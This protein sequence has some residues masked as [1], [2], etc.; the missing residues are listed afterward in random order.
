MGIRYTPIGPAS[1]L[2]KVGYAHRMARVVYLVSDL[3]FV[4]KIRETAATLGHEAVAVRDAEG[5]AA[6]APEAGLVVLD[7]R[8]PDA[9]PGLARLRAAQPAA[10]VVGF[11]DHERT[12]VMEEAEAQGCR[13]LAKGRFSTELP[14]LLAAL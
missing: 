7:L 5:L 6:A 10:R 3:L 1:S 2:Q 12:D 13:A 9:L 8:R 4:S 14:K 11:I